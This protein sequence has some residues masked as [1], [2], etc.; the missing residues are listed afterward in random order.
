[1]AKHVLSIS[2]EGKLL[3]LLS[4][5]NHIEV[6]VGNG[7]ATVTLQTEHDCSAVFSHTSRQRE[8]EYLEMCVCSLIC[9]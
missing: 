9:V 3:Y 1:M 6:Q 7:G 8:R 4:P 5:T 2:N